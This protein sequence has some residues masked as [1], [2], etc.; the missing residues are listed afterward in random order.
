MDLELNQLTTAKPFFPEYVSRKLCEEVGLES[1]DDLFYRLV[2]VSVDFELKRL[3][4]DINHTKIKRKKDDEERM[5]KTS[6]VH[7]LF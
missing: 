7:K 3:I 4:Q 5:L 2:S 1:S 6:D